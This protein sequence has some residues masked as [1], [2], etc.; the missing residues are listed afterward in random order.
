MILYRFRSSSAWSLGCGSIWGTPRC[1]RFFGCV[2]AVSL[3]PSL[4]STAG[5]TG[6]SVSPLPTLIPQEDVEE[7]TEAEI[8]EISSCTLLADEGRGSTYVDKGSS[9]VL[10]IQGLHVDVGVGTQV[11]TGT[12]GVDTDDLAKEIGNLNIPMLQTEGDDDE[13]EVSLSKSWDEDELRLEY[14]EDVSDASEDVQPLVLD[15]DSSTLASFRRSSAVQLSGD[16][17]EPIL[18][19]SDEDGGEAD[20][21]R[22]V[23]VTVEKTEAVTWTT[24]ESSSAPDSAEEDQRSPKERQRQ[25]SPPPSQFQVEF[26]P[27]FS[28][29]REKNKSPGE[30]ETFGEE[31]G[32]GTTGSAPETDSAGSASSSNSSNSADILSPVPSTS[33]DEGMTVSVSQSTQRTQS[34]PSNTVEVLSP[35]LQF[36]YSVKTF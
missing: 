24:E 32:S 23:S 27:I 28:P 20:R 33:S 2:T 18:E 12:K 15:D 1:Q 30:E 7:V 36:N 19:T 6:F 25:H 34:F 13:T 16:H 22:S 8:S 26:H 35:I 31:S 10:E 17:L 29:P 5:D 11:S 9:P 14:D 4:D 3:T 21:V